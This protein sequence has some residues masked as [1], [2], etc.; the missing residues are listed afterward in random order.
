DAAETA[1]WR[2]AAEA[3]LVPYDEDLGV[4]PQCTD[5]THYAEW[6]F[7]ATPPEQYPLLLHH[8]YY[9]L[10]RKQVIKQ[11]D[12]VLAMHLRGDAFTAEEKARNVAYYEA[13]TVRDS[14]LSACAQAVLAAEVGHLD[15]A[16]DYLAECALIDLHDL[17]GNVSN[18][19]HIASLAG[20]W[21]AV[22]AGLGGMRDHDG[23]L[24]FAPRLPAEL[25]RVAFRMCFRGSRLRV[26][27]VLGHATYRLLSG[28]PLDLAHHGEPIRVAL[29]APVTRPVPPSPRLPPLIH[30]AGRAPARR[31]PG[32]G[33]AGGLS[34]QWR[35]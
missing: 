12:L 15:L 13:R 35:G 34:P 9:D 23:R 17:H 1:E 10:Y 29:G 7:T 14:S 11:A 20:V 4:H 30:P 28:D 2:Q 21:V 31:T 8:P 18:G 24:T 16:Y 6:D 3:M 5:F 25:P 26:E 19:L 32:N 33:N 27:V 22:V